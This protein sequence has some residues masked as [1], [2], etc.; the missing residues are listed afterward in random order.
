MRLSLPL[1]RPERV[2]ETA[3]THLACQLGKQP[4]EPVVNV[5][6]AG[7][8]LEGEAQGW[9]QVRARK[10]PPPACPASHRPE[11]KDSVKNEGSFSSE[12]MRG[13][14][15]LGGVSEHLTV[16]SLTCDQNGPL[17]YASRDSEVEPSQNVLE[18]L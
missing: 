6:L 12:D 13:M 5:I 18:G 17:I 3:D 14:E 11:T 4:P 1:Q 16:S 7:V 10:G 15:T 8:Y 2:T 9:E